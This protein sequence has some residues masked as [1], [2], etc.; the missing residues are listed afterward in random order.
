LHKTV[1]QN[2]DYFPEKQPSCSF[3]VGISG[4]PTDKTFLLDFILTLI[5]DKIVDNFSGHIL[6][7]QKKSVYLHKL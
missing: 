7:V 1:P 6:S 2:Y 5:K 3:F 4:H